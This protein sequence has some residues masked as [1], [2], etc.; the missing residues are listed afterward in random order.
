MKQLIKVARMLLLKKV[1]VELLPRQASQRHFWELV[2]TF[3][4]IS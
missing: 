3:R 1:I 4:T 2:I